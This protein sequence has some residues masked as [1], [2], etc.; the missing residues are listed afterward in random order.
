MVQTVVMTTW[1]HHHEVSVLGLVHVRLRAG[2][3]FYH[4]LSSNLNFYLDA[5]HQCKRKHFDELTRIVSTVL[6]SLYISILYLTCPESPWPRS[7]CS[8]WCWVWSP[9][10]TSGCT[11]GQDLPVTQWPSFIMLEE[12]GQFWCEVWFIIFVKIAC[13][14]KL[15]LFFGVLTCYV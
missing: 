9:A 12:V 7:V 14:I 3:E 8:Q 6:E 15:Y 10:Q 4:A 2:A 11:A 1:T 5:A 13:N